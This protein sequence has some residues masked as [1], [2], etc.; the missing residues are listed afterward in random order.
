M[1]MP[2][3]LFPSLSLF[4]IAYEGLLLLPPTHALF[5]SAFCTHMTLGLLPYVEGV[6]S[7]LSCMWTTVHVCLGPRDRADI[8]MKLF[9]CALSRE[10]VA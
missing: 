3:V 4:S 6:S 10:T 2:P 7:G 1:G 8:D 5:F 9:R